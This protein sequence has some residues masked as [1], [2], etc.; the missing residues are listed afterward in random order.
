MTAKATECREYQESQFHSSFFLHTH[1]RA[2]K[3]IEKI[4]SGHVSV[5]GSKSDV[6][7]YYDKTNITSLIIKTT[8]SIY[9]M[10]QFVSVFYACS[11]AYIV[12]GIG[13]H[14]LP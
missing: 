10:E 11:D 13:H 6:C 8:F 3:Q 12:G 7:G 9:I 2:S 4:V 14:F 1:A 5:L